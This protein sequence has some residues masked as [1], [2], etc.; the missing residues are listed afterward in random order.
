M[1]KAKKIGILLILIG[2]CLPIISL[3]FASPYH[4]HP[5]RGLISNIQTMKIILRKEKQGK[6]LTYVEAKKAGYSDTEI[7]E[8]L[9]KHSPNFDWTSAK[10]DGY[11]D[12]E[13]AEYLSRKIFIKD[14]KPKISIPYKYIFALGCV[15]VFTGIGLIT[16]SNGKRR[17]SN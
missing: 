1:S 10:R 15:L 6:P 3:A 5:R 17:V 4:Y 8:Y 11:S 12:T 14:V 2:I 7:V 9:K 13:I 16:L